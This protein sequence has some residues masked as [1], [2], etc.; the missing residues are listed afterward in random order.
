FI[1]EPPGVQSL[2][3]GALDP[4]DVRFLNRHRRSPSES[5]ERDDYLDL[6]LEF[7]LGEANAADERAG[8]WALDDGRAVFL[9]PGPLAGL[10]LRAP[11]VDA[12]H[13]GHALHDVLQAAAERLDPL[14]DG[15]PAGFRLI[16][17]GRAVAG[18]AREEHESAF[19]DHALGEA[20]DLSVDDE[21]MT[22]PHGTLH[23]ENLS[24]C[25]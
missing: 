14:L 25:P 10:A 9:Q 3:E 18:D 19:G 11:L 2:V 20:H 23:N 5:V 17:H 15:V 24:A 13:E 7:G 6:E 22:L 16:A 4:R 21:G 8:R 12:C 1:S